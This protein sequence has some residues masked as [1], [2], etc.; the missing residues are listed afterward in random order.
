MIKLKVGEDFPLMD[1]SQA[2][3][4]E[5]AIVSVNEAFFD[6][7]FY[8]LDPAGDKYFFTKKPLKIG[9]YKN[10]AIP[11]IVLE[12]IGKF[13]LDCTINAFK[14]KSEK[15]EQWHQ[16]YDSNIVN[17]YMVDAR[18][19]NLQ[20]IRLLGVSQKIQHTI[21]AL[22]ELQLK[23]YNNKEEVDRQI[24]EITNTVPNEAMAERMVAKQIFK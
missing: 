13:A 18:T 17:L 24:I 2:N 22:V 10:A 16:N 21:K 12:F 8:S 23:K 4:E 9:V 11:F 3:G 7:V 15:V 14:I 20:A 1:S 6:I 19:N 5:K